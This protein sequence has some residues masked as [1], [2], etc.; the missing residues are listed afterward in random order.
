M[1]GL[2]PS[3][4]KQ[5]AGATAGMKFTL[6]GQVDARTYAQILECAQRILRGLPDGYELG[7]LTAGLM[8]AATSQMENAGATLEALREI[9]RA[10]LAAQG[11]PT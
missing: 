3:A 11:D 4:L 2:D 6:R 7:T 10:P 9:E 8:L 5:P 1:P